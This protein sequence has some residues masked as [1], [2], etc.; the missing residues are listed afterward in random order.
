MA[1]SLGRVTVAP[2]VLV[3]IARLTTLAMPGVAYLC[4]LG[5]RSLLGGKDAGGVRIEV[6]DGCVTVDVRI[7][8]EQGKNILQLSQNL[9]AKIARAI[10]NMVGM[11]VA[12]V[13]VYIADVDFSRA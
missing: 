8:V 3:S 9:Q 11:D 4:P 13:N 6:Q 5:V 10:E 1:D 2:D 7:V 12:A